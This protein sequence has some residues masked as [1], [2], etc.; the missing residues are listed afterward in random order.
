MKK[1]L[2]VFGIDKI[3]LASFQDK[4]KSWAVPRIWD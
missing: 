1:I 3:Q 4:K 2:T